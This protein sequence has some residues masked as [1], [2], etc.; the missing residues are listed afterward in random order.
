M[1]AY[2][3]TNRE[4]EVRKSDDNMRDRY[5]MSE[6][7]REREVKEARGRDTHQHTY[8]YIHTQL[9]K[10]KALTW[11]ECAGMGCKSVSERGLA[12]VDI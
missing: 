5:A 12:V 11:G 3:V 6:Q 8:I 9:L 1:Y 10:A 2:T 7:E 4:R